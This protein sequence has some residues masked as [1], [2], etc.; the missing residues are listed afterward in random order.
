MSWCHLQYCLQIPSKCQ[1]VTGCVSS[2]QAQQGSGR[3][4]G[5]E[6]QCSGMAVEDAKAQASDRRETMT[7][8]QSVNGAF[9][10]VGKSWHEECSQTEDLYQLTVLLGRRHKTCT[11]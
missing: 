4:L 8:S 2:G 7:S 5:G 9:T 6:L 11:H 3:G 1:R 10:S